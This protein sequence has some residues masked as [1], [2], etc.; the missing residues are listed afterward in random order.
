MIAT[1]EAATD[2]GIFFAYLMEVLCPQWRL[3]TW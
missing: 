3:A 1:I 2:W